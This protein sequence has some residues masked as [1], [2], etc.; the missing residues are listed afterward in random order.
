MD[1][2]IKENI[3]CIGEEAGK[4]V[5]ADIKNKLELVN[6]IKFP[7][8]KEVSKSFIRGFND[9]REENYSFIFFCDDKEKE[10]QIREDQKFLSDC[11]G[12]KIW[13]ELY[14][15]NRRRKNEHKNNNPI[16]RM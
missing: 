1:F 8:D 5:Y 4:K 14:K 2:I 9:Y 6:T 3:E 10:K 16:S 13:D 12:S 11:V 15:V 7:A